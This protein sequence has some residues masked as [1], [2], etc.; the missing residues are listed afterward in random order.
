MPRDL[1]ARAAAVALGLLVL[2]L[3]PSP[4]SPAAASSPEIDALAERLVGKLREREIAAVGVYDFTDLRGRTTELGRYVA[5]ELS[6]ALVGSSARG[7]GGTPRI[8]D[9]LRLAQILAE[10]KLESSGLIP[11]EEL[12][13]AARIAGI[14]AV[15]TGRLT[16]F[17]DSV[18]VAVQVLK[19]SSGESVA[20]ASGWL[21]K[22]PTLAE[23]EARVLTVVTAPEETGALSLAFEGPPR[24]TLETRELAIDLEGCAR[25]GDSVHCLVR[26]TARGQDR[27]FTLFGSTRA[28]LSSGVQV[29]AERVRVGASEATGPKGRA[30]S[31]LVE[32]VPITA[33]ASFDGV[34]RDVETLQVLELGLYGEDVRFS[35]VPIERP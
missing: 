6:S 21:P 24:R 18:H 16:A 8:V 23:L 26:V 32:G 5:E 31:P 19:V 4:A 20:A 10:R 11:P 1:R 15:V 28:V 34:P 25:V 33:S 13:E 35:E 12:R 2:A 29:P 14:D 17:A 7:A 9:R 27:S 22:T 30:G 3:T